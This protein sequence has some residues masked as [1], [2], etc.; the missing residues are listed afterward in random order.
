MKRSSIIPQSAA[1]AR[2]KENAG[3]ELQKDA[4]NTTSKLVEHQQMERC[5]PMQGQTVLQ[6]RFLGHIKATKQFGLNLTAFASALSTV[7]MVSIDR[8]HWLFQSVFQVPISTRTIR[9]MLDWLTAATKKAVAAIREQ[10]TK[11]PRLH[12]DETGLRVEGSLHWLHCAC[13]EKWSYFS[14]QKKWGKEATDNIGISIWQYTTA[15]QPMIC[16]VWSPYCTGTRLHGRGTG[17]GLGK[18]HETSST[19]DTPSMA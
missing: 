4:M 15:G 12:F 8:I 3:F 13:N 16:L 19:G 7:G 2:I 17:T 14:V 18:R 11:L 10:V 6:G 9:N 1:I 5:C